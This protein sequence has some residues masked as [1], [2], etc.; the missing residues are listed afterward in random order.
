M[1]TGNKY[2]TQITQEGDSW[3]AEI[4]RRASRKQVIVSKTQAGFASET[5]AQA[6]ADNELKTFSEQQKERNERR[7]QTR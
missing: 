6:W 4:T 1:A 3:T 2:A 7:D 5:E